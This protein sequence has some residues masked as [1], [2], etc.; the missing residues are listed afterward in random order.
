MRWSIAVVVALVAMAARGLLNPWFGNA[1]P[2]VFAFPAVALVAWVAGV[3]P[4][5]A[6]ALICAAWV[7]APWV[8]PSLDPE[9]TWLPMAA[10][11]PS[12]L[13]VAFLIS[14]LAHRLRVTSQ[15]AHASMGALAESELSSEESGST[16]QW[17]RA[18]MWL[19]ALV[20][21]VVF[22][23]VAW[24][25]HG[26]AV[27]QAKLALDRTVRVAE[28]HA[29]KVFE[30]DIALLNRT[31]DLLGD[32]PEPNLLAREPEIHQ[33]LKN[34]TS[35][36]PQ[37]QG[38]FVTGPSGHMVATNRMMPA[39]HHIDSS[40]REA[41]THHRDN[42]PQPLVSELL[43]SRATGEPFFDISIRRGLRD[44]SFGGSISTSMNPGYF[45]GFYRQLTGGEEALSVALV[46]ADGAELAAWPRTT[47]SAQ[48]R[49]A[50]ILLGIDA[51]TGVLDTTIL[52]G[53]EGFVTA[54]QLTPYPMAVMAWMSRG[55]A[56]APWY[57]QLWLLGAIMF[58]IAIALL[59]TAWIALQK[60]RRSLKAVEK[61]RQETFQRQ[62]A[63]ETLRQAQKLEAMGRLTGGVAHDFN[64]L[65]MVVSNNVFL[66]R[67][68]KPELADSAPLSAI[69]RAVG[70]GTKLTRQLLSFSRRQALRPETISLQ[71]HL[72]PVLEMLKTAIGSS[73]DVSYKV[74]PATAPI[75][76]DA[77]ELELALLNLAINAK[78]A[79]PGGGRLEITAANAAKGEPAGR[80][81]AFIVIVVHDTGSGIPPDVI[82]RVFEPFFT[83]KPVGHGTGLGLSQ[84]YGFCTRAGGTAQVE[85]REGEG[86]TVRMYL[87]AT[88]AAASAP[89]S[90]GTASLEH[91]RGLRVLL[92]EDNADVAE[93]TRAVLE[94]LG[95][96]V[97]RSPNADDAWTRLR[98]RPRDFDLM[99]SDIVMPGSMNG[100][101]LATRA[102]ADYPTLPVVLM[103][104]YSESM[105]DAERLGLE[106]IPKPTPPEVLAAVLEK[107]VRGRR[108]ATPA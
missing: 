10:F 25:L 71:R 4:A 51:G 97:I 77:A 23:G 75:E 103:S 84:V 96:E 42:G 105:S 92:V 55:A 57:A 21:L 61:L 29:R 58:P 34:M 50:A 7:L 54:R 39:P 36:L 88:S 64:N 87:K 27:T 48:G 95:C 98:R 20:P 73:I 3:A 43:T 13:L 99:L 56:L 82:D 9:S 66:Q 53:G 81:G 5:L 104:G 8:D 78:D 2:F 83:T 67:R 72:E 85:S 30:T 63:E 37:L 38:I 107:I 14:H 12:A 24:Y 101:E 1:L 91:L 79:M 35:D 16:L 46:H 106:V 19:G 41:F 33:A 40:D 45:Q 60:T 74:D 49:A 31:L 93:A 28:E 69:E 68:L 102:R 62:R 11:L 65:L 90:V 94:S 100:I 89:A 18:T 22:V 15:P 86:T 17:L 108:T 6:A 76:V 80:D 52:G 32:E 26:Q 59:Y 44:G 70:A 47:A